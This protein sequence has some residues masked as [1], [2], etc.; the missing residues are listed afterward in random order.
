[1]KNESRLLSDAAIIRVKIVSKT[2]IQ[3]PGGTDS[4]V[5]RMMGTIEHK[6]QHG[7]IVETE[8]THI[9]IEARGRLAMALDRITRIGTNVLIIG[10][11]REDFYT[12]RYGEPQHKL[13]ILVNS[14]EMGHTINFKELFSE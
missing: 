10:E 5:L 8:T 6:S 3:I 12:D 13:K 9:P 2:E 7:N 11:H 14:F 4:A 1:V